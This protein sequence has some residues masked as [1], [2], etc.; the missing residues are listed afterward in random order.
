MRNILYFRRIVIYT[1][2]LCVLLISGCKK[3]EYSL[4]VN[5]LPA[6]SGT[7][8]LSPV[9]GT[10]KEGTEVTLTPNPGSNYKFSSWSG[11]DLPSVNANISKIVMS[12]NMSVTANFEMKTMIRLKSGSNLNSGASIYFLALSKTFNY[13]GLT[14]TQVFDYIKTNADWYIDGGVIPFTTAYKDLP[15]TP[16]KYNMLLRC[17]GVAVTG[18]INIVSGQQSVLISGTTYGSISITIQQP[19]KSGEPD[20]QIF[21]QIKSL[22]PD[23][24]ELVIQK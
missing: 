22:I 21:E 7:V 4:N 16:G 8:D 24:T 18:T 12:K 23:Q 15:D 6:G 2:I 10:Y 3:V 20:L 5:I 11:T 9:G 19:K 14:S 1:F 13:L 17:S